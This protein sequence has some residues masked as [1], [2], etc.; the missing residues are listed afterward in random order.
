MAITTIIFDIG[1][2]LAGF[3]WKEHFQSFGYDDAMVERIAAA[4]VKSPDWNEYD[5]GVLSDE[6]IMASFIRN[7]PAIQKDIERVL[8]N[9]KTLV[10]RYDYAIPWIKDFKAKGYRCLY[11]SNFSRKAEKECAHALD[12]LPYLDGG[13]LSYKEK[14]IKPDEAIY[15][16]LIKRYQ[17]VPEECI[18]M[19]DSLPNVLAARKLGIHAIHFC[20]KEQACKELQVLL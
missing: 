11:L 13:I 20:S 14:V 19:D 17:L 12:F 10:K 8:G 5:R 18:F 15:R 2:V 16:L 6:E 7:D 4:T 9:F 1:N 3:T